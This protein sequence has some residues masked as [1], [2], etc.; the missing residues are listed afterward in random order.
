[1]VNAPAIIGIQRH[2]WF[3]SKFF[4]FIAVIL[5]SLS[6]V[7]IQLLLRRYHAVF[8]WLLVICHIFKISNILGK[9]WLSY[10]QE[11][12]SLL[13]LF[14]RYEF[15]FVLHKVRFISLSLLRFEMI[16]CVCLYSVDKYNILTCISLFLL[17]CSVYLGFILV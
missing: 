10:F 3:W 12:L 16:A 15:L 5:N 2:L 1:M 14:L 7:G 9:R 17:F 6:V 4:I 11:V 8:T 13:Y